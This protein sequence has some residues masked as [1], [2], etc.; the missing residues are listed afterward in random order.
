M[1]RYD[2]RSD[3]LL[4]D[5]SIVS[6]LDPCMSSTW[7][8]N[9]S[10]RLEKKPAGYAAWLSCIPVCSNVLVTVVGSLRVNLYRVAGISYAAARFVALEHGIFFSDH[11]LTI[12]IPT[13]TVSQ[14]FQRPD[15]EQFLKLQRFGTNLD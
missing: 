4:Q 2:A 6:F 10:P 14:S 12:R 15:Y 13:K 11:A 1:V 3:V 9:V 5:M 8:P 7:R